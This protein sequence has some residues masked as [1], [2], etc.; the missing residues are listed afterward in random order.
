MAETELTKEI[1]KRCCI[2]PKLI[3][4]AC[5]VAMKFAWGLVY[6]PKNNRMERT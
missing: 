2:I 4:P 1:K 3:R 5:M 6:V